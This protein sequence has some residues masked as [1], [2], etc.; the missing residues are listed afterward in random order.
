MD[1]GG[2]TG[3]WM[4]M[5]SCAMYEQPSTERPTRSGPFRNASGHARVNTE[6]LPDRGVP[7]H[8]RSGPHCPS[9][10]ALHLPPRC[11]SRTRTGRTPVTGDDHSDDGTTPS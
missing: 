1:C 3:L 11:S 4:A 8:P 2:P 6:R 10:T 5:W 7:H 9:A